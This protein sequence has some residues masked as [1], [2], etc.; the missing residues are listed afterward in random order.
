M[1]PFFLQVCPFSKDFCNYS[2]ATCL[3][4]SSSSSSHSESEDD[5]PIVKLKRPPRK[6]ILESSDE[7]DNIP[8]SELAK[9][10]MPSQSTHDENMDM[11][12]EGEG[13]K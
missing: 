1:L 12:E 8:L 13:E 7:E 9:E 10:A 11:E 2:Q 5:V 6:P 3:E 4:A